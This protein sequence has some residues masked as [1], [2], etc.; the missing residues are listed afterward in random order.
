MNFLALYSGLLLPWLSGTLWLALAESKL[1][2]NTQIQRLRQAGYGFF[3]GYAILFLVIL[4]DNKLTGSV[5]WSGVMLFL[6]VFTVVPA[7]ILWFD[8]KEE[9]KARSDWAQRTYGRQLFSNGVQDKSSGQTA[10]PTSAAVK[11]LTTVLTVWIAIHL[12]FIAVEIYSQPLYPWDAWLVWIY[13]AKAWFLAGGLVDITSAGNWAAATATNTYSV[14]A[15]FYP[16]L[17]SIIPYWAALSLGYWSETLINL[18]VLFA[19]LAIGMALYGQCHEYGL[20]APASLVA[21]YLLYSIPIFGT[22]LALAGYADIWMA[23]FVG[24]GFMAVIRGIVMPADF[25]RLSF[26]SLLGLLLIG[27]GILVKNEAVVWFLA[28]LV[29]FLLAS[30]QLR[31]SLL[32][33]LV[34]TGS[35][36]LGAALGY[37]HIDIPFI[38]TLGINNGRLFVPFI[39]NFALEVHNVWRMYWDNFIT[40]GSWNLLWVLVISSMLLVILLPNKSSS[41]YLA[42]RTSLVFF[43]VFLATQLFIFGFTDQGVW[44][45]TYTAINR[46]PLHFVPAL[47]FAVA[48]IAHSTLM[49][50]VSSSEKLATTVGYA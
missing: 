10:K 11:A 33:M 35:I 26:Q 16:Q 24:L 19:G 30:F 34:L 39:G 40:M 37:T 14:E 20:S 47:L 25:A 23:G 22:H 9:T 43:V 4:A 50:N 49:S 13:R 3:L 38:G 15:W 28:M 45:D 17:P 1:S 7:G 21:G 42:R 29:M 31:V 6:L 18:P 48:V 41:S 32:A 5:S 27:L 44:A 8:H 2:Q 12:I 46:L 36:T